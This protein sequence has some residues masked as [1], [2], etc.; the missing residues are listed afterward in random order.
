MSL[1]RTATALAASLST[2]SAIVVLAAAPVA[3]ATAAAAVPDT[4]MSRTLDDALHDRES[5]DLA[6]AV[7]YE[8][9]VLDGMLTSPRGSCSSPIPLPAEFETPCAAHDL[10]YDILRAAATTGRPLPSS[11]RQDI[12]R[13]L[14]DRMSSACR[15]RP[16][17]VDRAQCDVM[18]FAAHAAV[19][20]NSWRQSY[21]PPV[22]ENPT[23][24]LAALAAAVL[25][26][27]LVAA[28]GGR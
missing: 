28:G 8:P 1:R 5:P 26:A 15:A 16:S 18:A 24:L 11:A 25:A 20:G 17:I 27:L 9:V 7:G 23:R 14:F 19:Q 2:A 6:A 12:D 10:G 22:V 3:S 4:P 21:G 13:T